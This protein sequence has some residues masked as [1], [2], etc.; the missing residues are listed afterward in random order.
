M[1][2]SAREKHKEAVR[3]VA[4]RQFVFS[5][6]VDEGR[7]KEAEAERRIAI[8]EEIAEDYREQA[9]KEEAAGRLL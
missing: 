5:K 4:Y 7:M 6:R 8:M 2:F 9:E 3:E 1:A